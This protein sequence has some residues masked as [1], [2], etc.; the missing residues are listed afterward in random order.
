MGKSANRF[1]EVKRVSLFSMPESRF[2]L[3]PDGNGNIL[4]GGD[5]AVAY[6]PFGTLTAEFDA[7]WAFVRDAAFHD[8][9]RRTHWPFAATEH[10]KTA[11]HIAGWC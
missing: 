1:A 11:S 9:A 4:V 5:G 6:S 10:S 8:G 3:E 2:T 7:G